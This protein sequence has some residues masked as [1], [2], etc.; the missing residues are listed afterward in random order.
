MLPAFQAGHAG[1]IPVVRSSLLVFYDFVFSYVRDSSLLPGRKPAH[2]VFASLIGILE[3]SYVDVR[4][5]RDYPSFY[6][7][8]QQ[9]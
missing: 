8:C 3:H 5:W 2:A 7:K 4:G 1:S 9:P 6:P